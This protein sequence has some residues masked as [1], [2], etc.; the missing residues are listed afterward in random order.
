MAHLGHVSTCGPGAP[1]RAV[2]GM[3]EVVMSAPSSHQD[4]H[5]LTSSPFHSGHEAI[6]TIPLFFFII[7]IMNCHSAQSKEHALLKITEQ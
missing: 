4:P 5:K 6:P 7:I 1:P 2:L 3:Q